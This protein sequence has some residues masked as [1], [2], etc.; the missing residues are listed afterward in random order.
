MLVAI[1]ASSN[2]RFKSGRIR[3]GLPNSMVSLQ[4]SEK[5]RGALPSTLP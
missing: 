4:D 1:S 5:R 2:M 3:V